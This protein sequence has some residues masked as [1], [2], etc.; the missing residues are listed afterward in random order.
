MFGSDEREFV[1]RGF[2][3]FD[4]GFSMVCNELSFS[5]EGP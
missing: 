3:L 1:G 2:L 4:F 5:F